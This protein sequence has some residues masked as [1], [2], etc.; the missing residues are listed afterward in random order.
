M[1]PIIIAKPSPS[2]HR[3]TTYQPSG[4]TISVDLGF[5]IPMYSLHTIFLTHLNNKFIINNKQK[6]EKAWPR[7]QV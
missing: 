1:F 4:E 5:I 6:K 7:C 2:T 3:P